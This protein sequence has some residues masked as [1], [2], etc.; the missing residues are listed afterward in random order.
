L[1]QIAFDI[2]D[3]NGD[4]KISELDLFKMF[5]HFNQGAQAEE[6]HK[7]F[8]LDMCQMTRSFKRKWTIKYN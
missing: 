5:F 1:L 8:Y 7:I 2:F 6:F 4:N 3:T